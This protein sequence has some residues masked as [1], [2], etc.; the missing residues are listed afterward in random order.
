MIATSRSWRSDFAVLSGAPSR[1]QDAASALASGTLLR[2]RNA[3]ASNEPEDAHLTGMTRSLDRRLLALN[4]KR[5]AAADV[6][7]PNLK[8]A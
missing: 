3:I 5:V 6:P 4:L 2:R 7:Q 1:A 8:V